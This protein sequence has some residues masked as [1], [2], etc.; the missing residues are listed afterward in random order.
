MTSLLAFVFGLVFGVGLIL[1]GMT[2]PARV[3]GFLDVAG[4]W[5]ASLAF[6][7]GGAVLAALP[8]FLSARRR[9]R[10]V[11]GAA[12]EQPDRFRVDAALVLGAATFGFGWGLAGLCPGPALV[13]LGL[14]PGAVWLFV[15]ALALGLA[16]GRGAARFFNKRESSASP[17]HREPEQPREQ[18][19]TA[20]RVYWA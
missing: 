15:L 19:A 14:R 7:M 18:T 8:F 16:V 12:F 1:S 3:I 11:L 17:K 10:P 5:D 6:V 13:N 4:R 2:D 9:A 20:E